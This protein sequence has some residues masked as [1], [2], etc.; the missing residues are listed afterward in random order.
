MAFISRSQAKYKI[1]RNRFLVC[2]CPTKRILRYCLSLG[3]NGHLPDADLVVRVSG[4]QG[5]SVSG[6]GQ[7]Q[8]LWGISL[9]VLGDDLRAQLVDGLLVG[10]ILNDDK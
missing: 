5:L 6:P 9:G 1:H 8:A 7:G 10:Q 3:G 2:H 4:E